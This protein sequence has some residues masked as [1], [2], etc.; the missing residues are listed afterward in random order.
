MAEIDE[1]YVTPQQRSGGVG[2]RLLAS[3]QRDMA[4]RGLM[5]VQ[6]QLGV[7]NQ[8]GHEFY[9]RHGF[10]P[11]AGYAILDKPLGGLELG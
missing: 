11:R 2:S 6:L 9:E 1:F 8:R 5:R 4:A 3:A 7:R 10:R